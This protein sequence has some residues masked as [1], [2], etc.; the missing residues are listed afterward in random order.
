MK[1]NAYAKINLTL[2]IVG[3]RS[4]GLH[5]IESVFQEISLCDKIEIEK[6]NTLDIKFIPQID[7]K[8]ST[9]HT[10]SEIFFKKTR[11]REHAKIRIKKNIPIR[12]GLGGGSSDAATTLLLLNKLFMYPMKNDELIKIGE[13][14]GSDVSFFF[15]G[16]TALVEGKGNRVRLINPV[17]KLYVLLVI[18]SFSFS[19][20]DSYSQINGFKFDTTN[21][22]KK[23]ISILE[24]KKYDLSEIE[25]CLHNDFEKMYLSVDKNFTSTLRNLEQKTS[26]KFH[27]TGSGSVLFALFNNISEAKQ[28]QTKL[29]TTGVKTILTETR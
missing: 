27:L 11:I 7:T 24:K 6:N 22:T 9:A 21:S 8:K 12:S 3:K 5:N 2:E 28:A 18:P 20:K 1:Q 16:G 29:K 17:K 10:S 14:I 19:T 26:K 23:L 13:T 25:N 4:D 15:L